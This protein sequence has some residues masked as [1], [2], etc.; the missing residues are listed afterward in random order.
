MTV[1]AVYMEFSYALINYGNVNNYVYR[2]MTSYIEGK[3]WAVNRLNS[4][5]FAA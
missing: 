2:L 4:K 5:S 1:C 3:N